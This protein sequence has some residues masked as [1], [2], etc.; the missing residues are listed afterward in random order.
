MRRLSAV[1]TTPCSL[2]IP[3]KQ[4]QGQRQNNMVNI[5]ILTVLRCCRPR[6]NPYSTTFDHCSYEWRRGNVEES[7]FKLE[8]VGFGRN[9]ADGPNKCKM[10][11]AHAHGIYQTNQILFLWVTTS[12]APLAQ[13]PE[14]YKKEN[15]HPTESIHLPST[16]QQQQRFAH[17]YTN[18]EGRQQLITVLCVQ[19]RNNN[20]QKKRCLFERINKHFLILFLKTA[21]SRPKTKHVFPRK[22][23]PWQSNFP[24]S[25]LLDHFVDFSRFCSLARCCSINSDSNDNNNKGKP[26]GACF[27]DPGTEHYRGFS[28]V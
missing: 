25:H 2:L 19:L 5:Q 23:H 13:L 24:Q 7:L 4:R 16:R 10:R 20:K 12:L 3:L 14:K 27:I 8:C 15:R 21:R 26:V 9:C 17:K 18:T 22:R 28:F 11:T 6:S 1:S